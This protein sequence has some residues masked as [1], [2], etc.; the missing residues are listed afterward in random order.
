MTKETLCLF[1]GENS[2]DVKVGDRFYIYISR[3]TDDGPLYFG[4]KI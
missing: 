2:K 3:I 4:R 1:S